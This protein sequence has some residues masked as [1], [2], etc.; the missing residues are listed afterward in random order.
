MNMANDEQVINRTYLK[1][2]LVSTSH[3]VLCIQANIFMH[4]RRRDCHILSTFDQLYLAAITF[5]C[6][7]LDTKCQVESLEYVFSIWRNS[8]NNQLAYMLSYSIGSK[9]AR[10]C[11]PVYKITSRNT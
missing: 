9:N 10:S 2:S 1:S 5:I 4:I 7:D 6:G 8:F 11:Q 3:P